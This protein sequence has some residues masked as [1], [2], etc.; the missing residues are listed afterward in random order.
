MSKLT[1]R[2]RVQA[3]IRGEAVDRVP[4]SL[5][6]HVPHKDQDPIALAEE[7]VRLAVKYDYD[8]I[9]LCPYGNY[10]A[11]DYGLSCDFFCTP[12]QPVRERK[13][14]SLTPEEW[15]SLPVLPAVYG[16][17]GKVL[18]IV[19]ATKKELKRQ[20]L[21]LPVLQTIFNPLTTAAKLA[22]PKLWQD[23]QTH[24]EAVKAG[25]E[26]IAQTTINF[27][28]AN[29]EEG[30]DGFFYASQTARADV[31]SREDHAVFAEPY[32][33]KVAAAFAGKTW[34]NVVH[35][36]GENTY[37]DIL[38]QY[39][40]EVVNWHDQWAGPTLA[41]ARKRSGKCFLGGI[42]ERDV[43][44]NPE[45]DAQQVAEQVGR[46]IQE[47]GKEGLIIGPGCCAHPAV[48]ESH[49]Y[50]ARLAAERYSQ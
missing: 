4:F 3:A 12:T 13:F 41:E 10:G 19:T 43:F 45:V 30:A 44:G 23:I 50:A 38:S 5:W 1:Q 33:R 47:A 17:Y 25:L 20:G 28:N 46:A 26:A 40:V 11:Q 37:W 32:D 14:R 8:F 29:M 31:I 34:F 21:D 24:P 39:P 36:H 16:T 49:V 15:E 22:G 18:Q 35:I 2:E 48:I 42:N 9:K 27:I 7:S 6:F